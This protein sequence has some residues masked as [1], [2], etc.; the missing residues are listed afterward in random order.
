MVATKYALIKTH[1][2]QYPIQMMC[3]ALEIA[4]SAYY[5][6][7]N[8]S[9]SPR[10]KWRDEVDQGLLK[11]FKRHKER[12]GS[13]RL[14]DELIDAGIT[15]S[16]NTVA[17]RMNQLG[18]RA[19][20][21]RRFRVFQNN[22]KY[23][24]VYPNV[25]ERDFSTT[26]PNQ[27][28]VADITYCW[29]PKGWLYLAAVMDLDSR[30]IIG[31]S[32]SARINRRIVTDALKM[33]LWQRKFPKGVVV[34]TDQ[35]SQYRSKAYMKLIKK[36]RL[37]G[38]MSSKGCCYDNAVIESFFKSLKVECIYPEKPKTRNEMRKVIFDYV[39]VYYNRQR[40][41]SSLG[42]LTPLQKEKLNKPS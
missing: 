29:T 26:A 38:S 41:H 28:W 21:G 39:E 2:A 31:W 12:Y 23:Q 13:P 35:G 15:C 37:I 17:K 18:L 32:M 11:F 24:A 27:K 25:L 22:S 40:R 1:A 33:A 19:R 42:G 10:D 4:T 7:L 36:N 20:A 3:R 6:W 34:H 8:K 14:V 30:S 16:E 5:K 9:P